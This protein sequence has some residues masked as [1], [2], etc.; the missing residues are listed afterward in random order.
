MPRNQ[1]SDPSFIGAV[2]GF[3][4]NGLAKRLLDGV[5]AGAEK[6][7]DEWAE[8]LHVS[9]ETI[10]KVLSYLRKKKYL[11]YPIG[12]VAG[13]KP[14]QGLIVNILEK[15]ADIL[16]TM[17]RHDAHYLAPQ[18]ESIVRIIEQ[19][20]TKFPQL[21]GSTTA[22]LQKSLD[23]LTYAGNGNPQLTDSQNQARPVP[24]ETN[25]R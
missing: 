25:Y 22:L 15:K 9:E 7:V 20:V 24:A 8:E 18:L 16:E 13:F 21:R 2:R 3:H 19:A 1:N 10:R 11:L 4:K 23:K 17:E 14:Q 5:T 6:T 12:T